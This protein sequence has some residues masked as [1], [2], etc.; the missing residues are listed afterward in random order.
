M[1]LLSSLL[2]IMLE[3]MWLK[4]TISFINN[5][6]LC[7]K[8]ILIQ[9]YKSPSMHFILAEKGPSKVHVYCYIAQ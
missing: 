6:I 2:V 5:L 3:D 1:V 8:Q 9:M 7:D 4:M